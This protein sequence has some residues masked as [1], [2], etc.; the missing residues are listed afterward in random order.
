M[1]SS[2]F[3]VRRNTYRTRCICQRSYCVATRYNGSGKKNKGPKERKSFVECVYNDKLVTYVIYYMPYTYS[4]SF[5][6]QNSTRNNM[7]VGEHVCHIGK[8]KKTIEKGKK[9]HKSFFEKRK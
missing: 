1:R 3:G 6:F 5:K 4:V 7:L 2:Y 9:S 8:L